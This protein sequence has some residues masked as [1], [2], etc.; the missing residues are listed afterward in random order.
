MVWFMDIWIFEERAG[1][2][3][4]A[5]LLCIMILSITSLGSRNELDQTCKIYEKGLYR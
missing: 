2:L 1:V 3:D 5:M 4:T